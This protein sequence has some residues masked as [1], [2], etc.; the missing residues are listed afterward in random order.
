M[1][2]HALIIILLFAALYGMPGLGRLMPFQDEIRALIGTLLPWAPLLVA[3]FM[4]RDTAGRVFQ[5]IWD[6][7]N[8]TITVVAAV[9]YGI[10]FVAF[11]V[12]VMIADSLLL[13][14]LTMFIWKHQ[15]F[16]VFMV[17]LTGFA[18]YYATRVAPTIAKKYLAGFIILGCVTVFGS[19]I[20][21]W[22]VDSQW[23][24]F[25]VKTGAS[26]PDP[27]QSIV[28]REGDRIVFT[29]FGRTVADG[30]IYSPQGDL[31]DRRPDPPS[32]WPR[33]LG[34]LKLVVMRADGTEAIVP[35]QNIKSGPRKILRWDLGNIAGGYNIT[36]EVRIPLGAGEGRLGIEFFG[37]A[38]TDGHLRLTL[39]VN[40]GQTFVGRIVSRFLAEAG[41]SPTP[42]KWEWRVITR[43][44]VAFVIL[45]MLLAAVWQGGYSD[46]GALLSLGP[47]VVGVLFLFVGLM[48][49]EWFAFG[50]GGVVSLKEEIL[51]IV[52][53]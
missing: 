47:A 9:L 7:V 17:I 1:T 18:Y 10:G 11:V 43:I 15:V 28:V 45:L 29:A 42:A 35:I 33:P 40:P 51:A 30:K 41:H 39:I 48:I 16:Q 23:L 52:R 19:F 36:G 31:E 22:V 37:L 34:E 6:L 21:Q 13:G 5:G 32:P 49:F 53:R 14:P 24:I 8:K 3:L 46:R 4:M 25:K 50:G 44:V 27:A 20:S 38:P 12:P 26:Y 2:G